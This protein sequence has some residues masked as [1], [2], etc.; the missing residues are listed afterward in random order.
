MY[1]IWNAVSST[2]NTKFIRLKCTLIGV[3]LGKHSVFHGKPMLYKCNGSSISIGEDCRFRSRI[4]MNFQAGIMRPCTIETLTRNAKIQIG[5]GCGF[6]GTMISAAEKIVIGNNVMCGAN[7]SITDTDWHGIYPNERASKFAKKAPV[8]IED[9]VWLGMN[10]T[11]LKGSEIGENSVI[12]ANSVVSGK[13]P[14]NSLAGGI[15]ARVIKTL[16]IN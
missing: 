15:P 10:V 4:R 8:I 7:T 3:D 14:R 1:F 6:S 9:N 11:I 16:E 5:S 13:I 12:A 2:I